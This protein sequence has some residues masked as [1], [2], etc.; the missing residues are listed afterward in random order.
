MVSLVV[1]NILRA[2]Y[3]RAVVYALIL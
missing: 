1:K 2:L 3:H